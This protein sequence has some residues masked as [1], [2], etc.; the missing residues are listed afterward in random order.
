MTR[1]INQR[2]HSRSL[3]DRWPRSRHIPAALQDGP[4]GGRCGMTVRPPA[5][6]WRRRWITVTRSPSRR[7]HLRDGLH[8]GGQGRQDDGGQPRWTTSSRSDLAGAATADNMQLPV[9]TTVMDATGRVLSTRW[10]K[11]PP[12]GGDAAALPAG[13]AP[14]KPAFRSGPVLRRPARAGVPVEAVHPAPAG[15]TGSADHAV[16]P[17]DEPDL[18]PRT[19]LTTRSS[20]ARL[21]APLHRLRA[22]VGAD[23][24]AG[25]HLQPD[26]ETTGSQIGYFDTARRVLRFDGTS[27]TQITMAM[28]HYWHRGPPSRP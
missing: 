17:G 21:C 18:Q 2:T 24:N 4:G 16:G 26:G 1:T 5:P 14:G 6:G 3:S 20:Q 19:L 10:E 15:R 22:A 8:R 7:V 27:D 11:A 23:P 9:L 12:T 28:P 13:T 25:L